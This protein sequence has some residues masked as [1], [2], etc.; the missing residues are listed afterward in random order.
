MSSNEQKKDQQVKPQSV[1]MESKDSN[2]QQSSADLQKSPEIDQDQN[3]DSNLEPKKDDELKNKT[4]DENKDSNLKNEEKKDVSQI[5]LGKNQVNEKESSQIDPELKD[6]GNKDP[7]IVKSHTKKKG[8]K[9][10]SENQ[11]KQDKKERKKSGEFFADVEGLIQ[12]NILFRKY[13]KE[14][15]VQTNNNMIISSLKDQ[16]LNSNKDFIEYLEKGEDDKGISENLE[17]Y[18][19]VFNESMLIRSL[20]VTKKLGVI[21]NDKN[22]YK[23]KLEEIQKEINQMKEFQIEKDTSMEPILEYNLTLK[24]KIIRLAKDISSSLLKVQNV[25]G[26]PAREIKLS[27]FDSE[28][29][30]D[31]ISTLDFTIFDQIND[32]FNEIKIQGSQNRAQLIDILQEINNKISNLTPKELK[33]H[34]LTNSNQDLTQLILDR[35]SR[36]DDFDNFNIQQS[37]ITKIQKFLA[38]GSAIKHKEQN[39]PNHPNITCFNIDEE[40]NL[41]DKHE[42][43]TKTIDQESQ[44][45]DLDMENLDILAKQ[46]IVIKNLDSENQ[47]RPQDISINDKLDNIFNSVENPNICSFSNNK[48]TQI[49]E[50]YYCLSALQ[51]KMLS[52]SNYQHTQQD[53]VKTRLER[54]KVELESKIQELQ[55][56]D[57]SNDSQES[58][59]NDQTEEPIIEKAED[60]KIQELKKQ[61]STLDKSIHKIDDSLK[62]CKSIHKRVNLFSNILTTYSKILA[63]KH[64]ETCKLTK[65]SDLNIENSDNNG[66]DLLQ[67]LEDFTPNNI[68]DFMYKREVELLTK[69]NKKLEDE[70]DQNEQLLSK[71]KDIN[72]GSLNEMQSQN[73]AIQT[74]LKEKEDIISDLS[75][76]KE[77]LQ[78]QDSSSLL[79]MTISEENEQLQSIILKIRKEKSKMKSEITEKQDEVLSLQEQLQKG[80]E[81]I[82]KFVQK[83]QEKWETENTK[84]QSNQK[85]YL[86][87]R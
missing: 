26:K 38:T 21:F 11:H 84:F 5:E 3:L 10:S 32:K 14:L 23:Q 59:I 46:K 86:S 57:D 66:F 42:S 83:Y 61:I 53:E 65:N 35:I 19:K 73:N 17:N 40:E 20:S 16:I 34:T 70:L 22:K 7:K 49:F 67:N 56:S 4:M 78:L 63:K 30:D 6:N 39:V 25:V 50:I 64:F 41:D 69:K 9:E 81:E 18:L 36:I 76:K 15:I 33:Q 43:E 85:Y 13:I 12:T 31:F 68:I 75:L 51:E 77:K 37:E 54:T 82:H 58:L 45:L 27:D 1:E 71:I 44:S 48:N 60:P 47:I 2:N 24:S 72:F 29:I 80:K 55:K 62:N 87:E 74:K 79:I 8:G 52:L 28:N